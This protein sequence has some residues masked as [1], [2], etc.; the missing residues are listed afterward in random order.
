MIKRRFPGLDFAV[1]KDFTEILTNPFMDIAARFW[2]QPRYDAFRTC[3]RSM[4]RI[5]DLVDDR[6]ATGLPI[7]EPEQV[8]YHAAISRWLENVRH[9]SPEDSY[10][11]ELLATLD[12]FS[13]PLWPWE[14]L[15][16]AM[17]FDLD[18]DG[19]GTFRTFLRYTE[20]A[21]VAP[22]AVFVH[23]CGVTETDSDS[24]QPPSFDIRQAAR[25]LALFAYLVHIMRDFQKDQLRGLNYFADDLVAAHSL[26]REDLQRAADKGEIPSGL[27]NLFEQYR[28]IAGYYRHKA[29]GRLDRLTDLLEPRYLVSLEVIYGLYSLVYERIDPC[30]GTFSEKELNPT[31]AEIQTRLQEIVA[32]FKAD[33]NL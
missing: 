31:P 1:E 6:K 21:A 23:L 19:F 25:P 33:N 32:D 4:R 9:K 29:K 7:V 26:N 14:R 20:G 15:C 24:C 11:A 18:N 28:K 30:K 27:R 8:E 22:A 12:R 5:D 2:E 10:T 16:Q 17:T 3:Y 13:I